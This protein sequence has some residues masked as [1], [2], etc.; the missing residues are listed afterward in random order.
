M[1]Q[2][3]QGVQRQLIIIDSSDAIRVSFCL[4]FGNLCFLIHVKSAF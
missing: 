3:L 4:S 2:N 1:L